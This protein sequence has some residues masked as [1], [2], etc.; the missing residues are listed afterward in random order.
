MLIAY[1]AEH[2]VLDQRAA[3]R[4]AR[5][6]AMQLRNLLIGRNVGVVVEEE[7]R[8]VEPAGAAMNVRVA[9]ECVGSRLG[10]HVQVRARGRPLLRVVHRGVHAHLFNGFRRRA[11]DGVAD[12]KINRCAALDDAPGRAIAAARVVHHAERGHLAGALAVEQVRGVHPIQQKRIGSI[13][14]AVGPDGRVAQA[15]VDAGAAGQLGAHARGL[16]RQPGKAAGCQRRQVDLRVVQNVAVGGVHGVHQ[17]RGFHQNGFAG[18]A[19]LER[20]V[21]RGSTI[22]LHPDVLRLLHIE[23]LVRVGQRIRADGKVHKVIRP[24]AVGPRRARQRGLL[25][26]HSD[27]YVGNHAARRI[28]NLAGDAAKSLLCKNRK[29]T[30][31]SG[32]HYCQ[33]PWN[34]KGNNAHDIPHVAGP[35][36]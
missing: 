17:R 34:R 35:R 22:G 16:N 18:L 25:T 26:H 6:V 2:L 36:E 23:S 1:V 32:R 30:Q 28:G 19:H 3:G 9:V 12:G 27:R 11:G 24:R 10:A 20:G 15:G 14:L 5:R 33:Q 7:R 29:T 4:S 8:R 21:H 13:A 31:S